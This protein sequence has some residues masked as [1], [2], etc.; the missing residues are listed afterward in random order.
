M[1]TNAKKL[2][3]GLVLDDGLDS[4]DGVQQYI[5]A[6]GGWL[7]SQGHDVKYIVGETHRQDIANVISVSRNIKVKFNGNVGTM[8]LPTSKNKLRKLLDSENF[9]VLHVQMP[10]SPFMSSKLINLAYKNTAIIG[11]FH[12]APNSKTVYYSNK[13]L[14]LWLRSSLKKFDQFLCVSEAAREFAKNTFGINCAISPNVVDYDLFN[15]AKPITKYQS[16]DRKTILFLGRL[17]PR[18]GCQ[19]LLDAINLLNKDSKMPAFKLIICGKGFLESSL[20]NFVSTNNLDD[21]VEFVGFVSEEDKPSYY[22]S[23]DI[24]VFPSSGGESFGIVLIEAMASGKS[25]ILAGDNAGYRSVLGSK[26]EML[27]NPLDSVALADNLK[28]LLTNN[29][30]RENFADWGENYVKTFDIKKVGPEI[31]DIY[32]NTLLKKHK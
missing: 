15:S 27:F 29:S 21:V 24:S 32:Q 14:G 4:L 26:P 9:D 31:L 5:L 2:K 25:A 7:S 6:I 16:K 19:I 12:I 30:I 22:A 17:V 10:Y 1:T 28:K 11:S 23:A 20:K 8:P 3:I 18:K 13:L